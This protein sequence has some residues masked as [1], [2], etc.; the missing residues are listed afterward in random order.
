MLSLLYKALENPHAYNLTQRIL[1]GQMAYGLIKEVVRKAIAPLSYR[2]VL[3]VGC[4]TGIFRECFNDDYTGIDVNADYIRKAQE[5]NTGRFLVGDAMV[6]PFNDGDFDLVFTVGVLHHLNQEQC[7]KMLYEMRRV[8][9]VGGHILIVDGIIPTNRLNIIG[10]TLA[11]LDRGRYKVRLEEFKN[12]INE[13]YNKDMVI[14]LWIY[15]SFPFEYIS[16]LC[17]NREA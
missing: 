5:A 4:G 7:K 9:K 17:R 12:M 8:S 14:D 1:G 11:K 16:A 2:T 15:K 10:Y 6:M 13:A 3:D